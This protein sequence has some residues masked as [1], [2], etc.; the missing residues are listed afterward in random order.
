MKKKI[1]YLTIF[2]CFIL[3]FKNYYIL[4][5][6]I[7]NA[8]NLWLNNVFPFLFIMIILNDIL[9]SLNIFNYFSNKYNYIF[10][11]S[12]LSGTPSNAYIIKNLYQK[13]IINNKV[14]NY[15]LLTTYFCNPLFLINILNLLFS[16]K[17]SCKI[18]FIH[19]LTKL[20]LSIFF[21]KKLK[22]SYN[23][24]NKIT[25]N[26]SSSIKKSLD[27]N[28]LVLGTIIFF[29]ILTN[30]FLKIIR[31]PL[32]IEI[33]LKGLL[34]LTQGLNGLLLLNNSLFIKELFAILFLSFGGLSIHLQI[35]S[36]LNETDLDYFYF[37]KGRIIEVI[38][39]VF[40]TFLLYKL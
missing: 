25:F 23:T 30:I 1:I 34:E 36:I 10:F 22:C 13:K 16:K 19:Y 11:T 14:A 2:S 28:I 8:F 6:T 7:F 31:L 9:L 12:L 26:L 29:A 18:L 5:T 20:I 35:K 4:R 37:L 27:T 38:I 39:S 15:S 21:Y 33:L 24:I 17:I 3:I 32:I 40:L